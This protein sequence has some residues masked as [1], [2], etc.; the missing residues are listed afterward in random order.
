MSRPAEPFFR[1]QQRFG[2]AR[3]EELVAAVNRHVSNVSMV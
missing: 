1:E 3:P 2:T